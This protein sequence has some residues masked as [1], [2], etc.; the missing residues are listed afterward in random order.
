MKKL[1][2]KNFFI[3][4]TVKSVIGL[5]ITTTI[6][7]GTL[8]YSFTIIS[9]ELENYFGWS[10]SFLFGVFSL[11]LLLGGLITPYI[12]KKLDHHGARAIMSIGSILAFVGLI[13]LSL[14]TTKLEYILAIIF[15][16]LVGTF[17]LYEAAFVAFSQIAKEKARL[18]MAQITFIAGFASTIF[19]PFISYLLEYFSWQEVY[20]I[21]AF[22]HLLIAFPLHLFTIPKT[23]LIEQTTKEQQQSYEGFEE[24]KKRKK[25]ILLVGV[26][27]CS[28]AIPIA[29]VQTHLIGLLGSFGVEATVAVI[30]GMFIGPSQVGARVLEMLLA[31]KI[32]PV[33]SAIISSSLLL[34]SMIALLLAGYSFA[35]AVLFAIFYGAGQ[36]LNY[37]ARGG[38]PLYILGVNN[39]GKNSGYLTLFIK[40]VTAIAPFGFAL[41]MDSFGNIVSVIILLVLSLVSVTA[42][43]L[44]PKGKND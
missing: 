26:A 34:F 6:G 40:V 20:V 10:K 15:L 33:S 28:I 2:I 31:K 14:V 3:E 32:S 18:P 42:L 4:G 43:Y 5:G 27:L 8:F 44:I 38:L 21:L 19:W 30:L 7:Y 13:F 17:V 29:V 39:Y 9:L 23:T 36:G 1:S 41:S 24:K 37:I 22:F 16:E 11:G 12:G 25:S 35:L